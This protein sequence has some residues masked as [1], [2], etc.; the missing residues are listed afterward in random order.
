MEI[1]VAYIS[2]DTGNAIVTIE[3]VVNCQLEANIVL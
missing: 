3:Q 1:T 2:T